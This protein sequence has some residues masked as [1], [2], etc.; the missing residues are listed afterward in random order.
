[1]TRSSAL[2]GSVCYARSPPAP[3]PDNGKEANVRHN[4]SH[5]VTSR[6]S[7]QP[8]FRCSLSGE[9]EGVREVL[10]ADLSR[11]LVTGIVKHLIETR[12]H[13]DLFGGL[14]PVFGELTFE[15]F[16]IDGCFDRFEATLKRQHL[17]AAHF[18][19]LVRFYRGATLVSHAALGGALVFA[20]LNAG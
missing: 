1:M 2:S 16:D 9:P 7:A 6:R 20:E 5:E 4:A 3:K 14:V 18:R 8:V 17:G 13:A 15:H 11:P 10:S 19:A 12:L